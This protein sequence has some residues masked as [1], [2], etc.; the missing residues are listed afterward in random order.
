MRG[1]I[2]SVGIRIR[3]E[4]DG[5]CDDDRLKDVQLPAEEQQDTNGHN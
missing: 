3:P 1:R 2:W 5:E 4:S